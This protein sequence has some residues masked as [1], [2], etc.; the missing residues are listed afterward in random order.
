MNNKTRVL[1]VIGGGEFGGAEQHILNLLSSVPGDEIEAQVV[2]FYDSVFAG[3][4]REAGIPVVALS[5]Y[6]RFDV[7]LLGGLSQVIRKYQPDIVHSHGVKANLFARLASIRKVPAILTTVHSYLRYDYVHP[8]AFLIVSILEKAT[9]PLND[10][11]IA[12]SAAIR[13]ILHKEGIQDEKI[14]LIYNG[15]Q[16]AP[17]RQTEQRDTDRARLLSEW[18]LPPDTLVYGTVARFVPV[19]GLTY[20][21]E[22]FAET[23]KRL[24]PAPCHLVMV[25]DGPERQLLE[26][27]AQRLGVGDQ[28]VF[29]GFRNDIPACLH[30]FDTFVM[31]SLHE[32]LAYTILEAVASE[33]PV[34]ATAV[35]GIKE[36]VDD[37]ETGLLVPSASVS[38]L[39]QAMLRFAEDP[40]L[41][42]RLSAAAFRKLLQSYTIE[43]MT[44]QT[45]DLYHS[46]AKKKPD[47][48]V[49]P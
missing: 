33:V 45:V 30:A 29:T 2:C 1:H 38:E 40:A 4:L 43:Q 8:L 16:I 15:I 23:A 13:N 26:E 6:G 41:R 21:I 44:A 25:G 31:S 14:S 7:R 48:S 49:N 32:G 17:F 27:T 3:K 11:Y 18:G 28:V 19:K 36:F 5:Q 46:L 9:R 24:A 35:G 10:Y 39:A 12:V 22:A 42:A 20:M 37:E 47:R 34:V